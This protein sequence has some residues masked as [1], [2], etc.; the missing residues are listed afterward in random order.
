MS[1]IKM[2]QPVTTA[3]TIAEQTVMTAVKKDDAL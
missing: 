2:G 1:V 3:Y